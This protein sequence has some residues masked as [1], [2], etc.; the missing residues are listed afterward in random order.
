MCVLCGLLLFKK[1]LANR[2]H[3][4]KVIHKTFQP[5]IPPGQVI[6]DDLAPKL[7]LRFSLQ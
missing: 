2:A 7:L 3:C 6:P 5:F 4:W 1:R